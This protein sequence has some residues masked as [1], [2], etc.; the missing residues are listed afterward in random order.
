[1]QRKSREE[2]QNAM[3][4]LTHKGQLLM[5]NSAD[6]SYNEVNTELEREKRKRKATTASEEEDGED[7]KRS[8]GEQNLE[9]DRGS[10]KRLRQLSPSDIDENQGM[11]WVRFEIIRLLTG[12]RHII[13]NNYIWRHLSRSSFSS[14]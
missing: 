9:D 14:Q 8:V 5:Y 7:E 4:N 12:F 10:G 1:M 13:Y 2:I 3:A 11:V 6:C